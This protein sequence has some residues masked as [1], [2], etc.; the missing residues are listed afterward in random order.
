MIV[1]KKFLPFI[2]QMFDGEGGGETTGG[3]TAGESVANSQTEARVN[4][5]ASAEVQ[6]TDEELEAEFNDLIK[7]KFKNAYSKRFKEGLNKRFKENDAQAQRLKEADAVLSRVAEM[8][9]NSDTEDLAGLLSRL[10][11]IDPNL[12]DEAVERGIPVETLREMKKLERQNAQMQE[13]ERQR[14]ADA[15]AQQ[16]LQEWLEEADECSMLYGDDFDLDTELLNDDFREL[17]ENGFTVRKAFE[18][19][20]LDELV[21]GAMQYAAKTTKTNIA[22]DIRARGNR[23]V[24]NGMRG[25]APV[26]S[27]VDINS[28]SGAENGHHQQKDCKRRSKAPL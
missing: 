1:K 17:L 20:H 21:G 4:A 11:D 7:G 9:G 18:A 23:P 16:Q 12:Q 13:A 10:D 27:S 28:L 24:E 19:C 25:S 22:N 5:N 2:L 15:Q 8:T 14:Q 6:Q 26:K 3:T